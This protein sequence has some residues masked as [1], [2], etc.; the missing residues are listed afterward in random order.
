MIIGQHT[1]TLIPLSSVEKIVRKGEWKDKAFIVHTKDGDRV[2]YEEHSIDTALQN[3]VQASFQSNG[4]QMI[5]PWFDEDGSAMF[6]V[7][8]ILG[9]TLD[10]TGALH[11]ITISGSFD[12]PTILFP[13]GHVEKYEQ[14]WDSF[15][16]YKR[17]VS[18]K[19]EQAA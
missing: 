13:D 9:F 4:A 14:R 10:A 11:A 17:E 2:E 5:E 16:D 7:T 1:R 8:N 6:D 18:T 3:A 12:E 19:N 15:D